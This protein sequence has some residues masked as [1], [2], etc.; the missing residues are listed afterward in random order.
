MDA[1]SRGLGLLEKRKDRFHRLKIQASDETV[2][3]YKKPSNG[4]ILGLC[5][6]LKSQRNSL[7]ILHISIPFALEDTLLNHIFKTIGQLAQ[8]R[9]LSLSINYSPMYDCSDKIKYFNWHIQSIDGPIKIIRASKVTDKWQPDLAS[10]LPSLENLEDFSFS[11][12]V[13][14][15]T[16][17]EKQAWFFEMMRALPQVKRLR[18]VLI[19]TASGDSIT[20]EEKKITDAILEMKSIREIDFVLYE[21]C[22]M[23]IDIVR[24]AIA[25]VNKR[26]CVKCEFMF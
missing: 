23:G 18:K 14:D 21:S 16:E 6:F 10:F 24:T 26:Q 19:G 11:F 8:L 12:E 3:C 1:L 22:W 17:W 20:G 9:E 25:Q 2:I 4:R 15:H 13:P 5:N 7:K